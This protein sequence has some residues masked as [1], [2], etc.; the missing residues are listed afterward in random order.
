[1]SEE[2]KKAL[3][4]Y[5]VSILDEYTKLKI[6]PTTTLVDTIKSYTTLCKFQ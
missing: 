3:G 2:V 4:N 6:V 5:L 1:M